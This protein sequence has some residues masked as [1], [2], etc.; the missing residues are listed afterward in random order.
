VSLPTVIATSVVRGSV[1][2]QSHGG[3]FLVDLETGATEQVLDW[4]TCEIDFAGRGADRGLRGIAFVGEDI[5]I[6]AS[7]ELFLFDT[8][9]NIRRSF[10]NPY[11]KHC[12]EICTDGRLIYL[13]STG[14]NSVLGFDAE[15][16]T[17]SW[18]LSLGGADA[19]LRA[20][21]FDPR[22]SGPVS[23][24]DLHL[25][26]IYQDHRGLFIGGINCPTLLHFNGRELKTIGSLPFG[27][28]NLQPFKH[29]LLFND[30]AA[31]KVRFVSEKDQVA[32][33]VP[34]YPEHEIINRFD[35]TTNIARQA[36]GRGLCPINERLIAA[37]SSPS[38]ISV[39]DIQSGAT[40]TTVNFSMDIRNA[41]HGLEVWPF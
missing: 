8:N 37:G 24:S 18:G 40:I 2:G 34:R 31:D 23:R 1:Q 14:F 20:S 22:E 16:K 4:N 19:G 15:S 32:F 26:S 6:A 35:D 5:Y 33:D 38:T 29:G 11:L 28:H 21:T 41:I 7:D 17:F 13:T 9:F 27:T 39:H 25:N 3:T 10:R 12:H 36:F 30:S